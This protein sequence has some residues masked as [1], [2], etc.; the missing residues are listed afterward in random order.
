M[1]ERFKLSIFILLSILLSL[2]AVAQTPDATVGE[3][4]VQPDLVM[5][6]PVGESESIRLSIAG[7]DGVSDVTFPA[8]EK[9]YLKIYD[10]NGELLEDGPYTW[11]LEARPVVDPEIAEI[12]A[13]ARQ[14]GDDQ[15]VK[16]L[17]KAGLL[18]QGARQFGHLTV[19]QGQFLLPDVGETDP[20]QAQGPTLDTPRP[21][22]KDYPIHDDLIVDGST[23]IGV[24][25]AV[26]EDFGFSTLRL[27]EHNLRIEFDD[28]SGSAGFPR[29]DWQIVA[30][31]ETHGGAS[32]FSIEDLT[33]SRVPFTVEAAAPSHA[34]YAN[35]DGRIG[36]RTN[37]PAT[38]MHLVDGDSAILRLEQD[39]SQGFTPYSWDVGGNELH[40]FV[41]D[42][43]NRNAMPLRV[44]AG[45]PHNSLYVN[46]EGHIGHNTFNPDA[47]LHIVG[48]AVISDFDYNRP[49]EQALEIQVSN[50]Q[51]AK[52]LFDDGDAWVIGGGKENRFIIQELS[53][54]AEFELEA[55]GDLT[56]A[57]TL[58]ESSDVNAKEHFSAVDNGEILALVQ[59]LPITTWSYKADAA[60][61]RHIGPMA[62]DF[63]SAF[64][65]GASNKGL[66]PRDVAGVALAAIQ[67]LN[68]ELELERAR[69]EAQAAI[70]ERLE[71]R[72]E[73]LETK[74][75]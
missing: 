66:A 38:E 60:R 30:N 53:D 58:T 64:G 12:L 63:Y 69:I 5:W 59:A 11:Q 75:P 50:D 16:E 72:L 61:S 19:A 56:I 46:A 25:C 8:G 24:D 34:L 54:G 49:P 39:G 18:P 10:A 68:K 4:F 21:P 22:T 71:A 28:T 32:R 23:C 29:N 6:S 51:E 35:R 47:D 7:P 73:A 41:R 45:A 62:Q 42:T 33:H 48:E 3:I 44:L 9:P 37:T 70:I 13:E 52:M 65:F 43:T 15:A 36:V 14:S 2:T 20:S 55:S 27:K 31:D 26:G 40:F 57:G 17:D 67:G 1:R 74:I